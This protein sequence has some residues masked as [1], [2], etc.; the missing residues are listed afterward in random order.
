MNK[1]RIKTKPDFNN[2]YLKGADVV[3]VDPAF[4]AELYGLIAGESFVGDGRIQNPIWDKEYHEQG[5]DQYIEGKQPY[6][7]FFQKLIKEP[8]FDYW[9]YIYGDF[10]EIHININK[11]RRGGSLPWHFDGYDGTFLQILCY[12]NI[13]DF[14]ESDGG[15]LLIGR[16]EFISRDN[17]P[18]PHWDPKSSLD[19]IPC[20]NIQ[21]T[22][23]YVPSRNNVVI[24][25]N[26][27]PSFVHRVTEL[28]TDKNRHTI[29]ATLGY[30]S[31]WRGNKIKSGYY[32]DIQLV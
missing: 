21:V 27:D 4:N 26:I 31:L 13:E 32:R 20:R 9:N 3:D 10:D 11:V 29:I 23:R 19:R 12:P 15:H 1:N 16:P 24:L 25:N 8:Y 7:N 18:F 14:I 5:I 6:L 2:F 30:K 28:E 17:D 22:K